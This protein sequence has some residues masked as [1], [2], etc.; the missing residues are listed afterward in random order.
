[1]DV[2]ADLLATA[3]PYCHVMLL[4]AVRDLGIEAKIKVM[5]VAEILAQ[6]L[7]P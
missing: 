6:G 7:R 3:C 4:N 2:G 1:M 5:D